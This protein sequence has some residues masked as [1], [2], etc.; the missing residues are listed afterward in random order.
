VPVAEPVTAGWSAIPV[1][2]GIA[3]L[4]S[5][6]SWLVPD[7]DNKLLCASRFYQSYLVTNEASFI[8]II[9]LLL[10]GHH[11]RLEHAAPRHAGRHGAR[12][13]LHAVGQRAR[14]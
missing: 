5:L 3:A 6:R 14:R 1:A 11:R 8:Y 9:Y 10:P 13:D 7:P 4:D 12:A 2:S